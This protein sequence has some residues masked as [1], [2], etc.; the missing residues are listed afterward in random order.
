MCESNIW[1]T[2]YAT[3]HTFSSIS[4]ICCLEFSIENHIDRQWIFR[5]KFC[6]LSKLK[7]DIHF[8]NIWNWATNRDE[9][10]SLL[11]WEI[12]NC[13]FM[14]KTK[15]F[16][17]LSSRL[18]INSPARKCRGFRWKFTFFDLKKTDTSI[19]WFLK[20]LFCKVIQSSAN[21]QK[22]ST[23]AFSHVRLQKLYYNFRMKSLS[24]HTH[25]IQIFQFIST[26]LKWKPFK[27]CKRFCTKKLCFFS[28]VWT[29]LQ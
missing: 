17:E 25:N 9:L 16:N 14:G 2:V 28:L 18:S 27:I 1:N 23:T 8:V 4:T 21:V 26:F 10:Y 19:K 3:G 22:T 29:S 6:G 24:A 13:I 12:W 20:R 11:Y 15:G 5:A 7:F